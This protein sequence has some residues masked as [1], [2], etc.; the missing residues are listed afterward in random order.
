MSTEINLFDSTTT[1]AM[2]LTDAAIIL[3]PDDD[4]AIVKTPLMAGTTLLQSSHAITLNAMI[5][6]AHKVAP[7]IAAGALVRDDA[8]VDR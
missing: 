7:G 4:V 8:R 5:P 3:H 1:Q 6:T 2:N